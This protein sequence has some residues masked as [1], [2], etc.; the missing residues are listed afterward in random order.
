MSWYI[1]DIAKCNGPVVVSWA[2]YIHMQEDETRDPRGILVE[3]VMLA[4]HTYIKW[5]YIIGS[6]PSPFY[7]MNRILSA[8]FISLFMYLFTY[9]YD[10]FLIYF[11]SF[12]VYLWNSIFKC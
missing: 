11:F 10:I 1:Q 12:I 4:W 8:M 3:N 2:C 5:L 6:I 9:V 7:K